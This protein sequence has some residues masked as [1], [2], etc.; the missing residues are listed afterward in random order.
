MSHA[1]GRDNKLNID[2]GGINR[3][4]AEWYWLNVKHLQ[5]EVN[6]TEA[7]GIEAKS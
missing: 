1:V 5:V 3:S 4:I 7:V 6:V 2:S